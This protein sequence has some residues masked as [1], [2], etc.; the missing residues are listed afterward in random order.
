[1]MQWGLA[2]LT[3]GANRLTSKTNKVARKYFIIYCLPISPQINR[4][5]VAAHCEPLSKTPYHKYVRVEIEK[6]ARKVD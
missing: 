3:W 5:T 2:R 1:M 6:A 4:L